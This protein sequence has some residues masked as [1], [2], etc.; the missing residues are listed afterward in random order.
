MLHALDYVEKHWRIDTNRI[1]LTGISMGAVGVVTLAA[2]HPHLFASGQITCGLL[3]HRPVNNLLT[4][5][6]YAIHSEDDWAAPIITSR[7]PLA[8][9]RELGGQVV[10]DETNGF[11]HAPHPAGCERAGA[12]RLRQVR[13]DS[14]TVRRLDFTALSGAA[15]RAWWAEVL[16]WGPAPRPAHFALTAGA[17]NTLDAELSNITRLRLRIGESPFDCKQPLR[18]SVGGAPFEI[19]A[20]LPESLVLVSG[21]Q[22]WQAERNTELPPFRLHTPGGPC[23]SMTVRHC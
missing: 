11:G 17:D 2:D 19:P 3:L 10:F 4:F 21:P 15:A 16:E 18:V 12:W 6:V 23:C 14:R 1:H 9:L 7:G 20:P 5:P 22:G 8:R 13:P